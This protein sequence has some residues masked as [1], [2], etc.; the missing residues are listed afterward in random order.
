VSQTATGTAAPQTP[1]PQPEPAEEPPVDM[2]RLNDFTNGNLDDLRDLV[3][4]YLSQTTGQVEQL[5]SAVKA[6]SA[7]EVR[8]I[9]HSCAGASATCGM[10]RIVQFLR[11]MEHESEEGNLS[12]A[13]E[14]NR[15]VGEEFKRIKSFLE[16]HMAKQS[17]AAAQAQA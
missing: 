6:G 7:A 10:R 8:R 14:L 5:T 3:T 2:G 11:Q 4:L 13:P 15:Q 9:A 1:A 12:N 16:A 17:D